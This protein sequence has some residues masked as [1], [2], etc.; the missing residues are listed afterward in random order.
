MKRLE[1]L[2]KNTVSTSDIIEYE[3]KQKDS[4]QVIYC[5]ETKKNAEEAIKDKMK[6]LSPKIF[7]YCPVKYE[8][9]SYRFVLIPCYEIIYYYSMQRGKKGVKFL[10]RE[11]EFAI[12]FDANE[13]HG[14]HFDMAEE[15]MFKLQKKSP[16]NLQSK[17]IILKDN[18]TKA[19]ME[20]KC[21]DMVMRNFRRISRGISET[22]VE[23][24]KKFYRPA[25]EMT[26]EAKGK[27]MIRYGYLDGYELSSEHIS[28]LKVRIDA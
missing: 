14:F 5:T 27:E 7:G 9:T 20:K 16:K 28:G 18:C 13:V 21:K 23:K 22:K 4:G 26:V 3:K 25:V 10:N 8:L 11:G 24:T 19:E 2:E 6:K 17:Y 1:K 15:S 12:I